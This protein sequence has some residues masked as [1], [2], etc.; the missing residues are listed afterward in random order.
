MTMRADRMLKDR[1]GV[2][3]RQMV[4][5]VL[6]IVHAIGHQMLPPSM[7]GGEQNVDKRI[8][9]W[10]MTCM[11]CG[12]TARVD[13]V[14]DAWR[15]ELLRAGCPNGHWL[16]MDETLPPEADRPAL[17]EQLKQELRDAGLD[18]D[19]LMPPRKEAE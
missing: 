11:R 7:W 18:P 15:G 13:L 1:Y 19:V 8:C 6:P 5:E 16:G 2:R 3:L 10:E 14:A 4:Q 12:H 9:Y 17:L